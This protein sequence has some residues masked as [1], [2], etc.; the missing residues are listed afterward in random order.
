MTDKVFYNYIDWTLEK[1]PRAFYVGKGLIKRTQRRERNTY[2]QRIAAKYGWRREVVLATKDES[3]AFEEEKRRIA[4]LGT[5]EDGTPGRWGANLTEGGG[6]IGGWKPSQEWIKARSGENNPF[7]GVTGENHP[8]FGKS[9]TLEWKLARSGENHHAAKLT[10]EDV[11][12]IRARYADGNCTQKQLAN[13]YGV[14]QCVISC[15]VRGKN[16]KYVS[17]T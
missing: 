12:E 14:T 2:W 5:F 8:F 9:H 16:W 4:E 1:S 17:K 6:G 3:F 7:F 10:V 11:K 15:I 13:V